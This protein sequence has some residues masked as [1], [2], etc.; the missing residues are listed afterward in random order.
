MYAYSPE[1]KNSLIPTNWYYP[2]HA[3]SMVGEHNRGQNRHFKSN[4][5]SPREPFSPPAHE[6]L[7]P[8]VLFQSLI[9]S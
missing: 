7:T 2:C 6:R 9:Q 4:S 8:S 1:Q 5:G 3:L